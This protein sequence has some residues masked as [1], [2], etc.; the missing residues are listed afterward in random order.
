MASLGAKVL[1]WLVE[2][3]MVEQ[4]KLYVRS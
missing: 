4:V 2:L 1:Q 3:E